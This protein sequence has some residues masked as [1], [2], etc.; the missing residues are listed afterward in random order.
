MSSQCTEYLQVILPELLQEFKSTMNI[1]ARIHYMHFRFVN[2]D[3]ADNT[4][5]VSADSDIFLGHHIRP[6]AWPNQ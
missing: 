6:K 4:F 2:T 3:S 1:W 5:T